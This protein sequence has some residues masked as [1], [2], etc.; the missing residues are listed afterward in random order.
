MQST[1]SSKSQSKA[2]TLTFGLK[3]EAKF[4]NRSIRSG[5]P[6]FCPV[7]EYIISN[8]IDV[9]SYERVECCRD[10]EVEFAELDLIGWKEGKRPSKEYI[11]LKIKDREALALNRYLNMEK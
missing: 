7:C 6:F 9:E 3:K 4:F 1:T 10:C 8:N 2:Q 11:K 5:V